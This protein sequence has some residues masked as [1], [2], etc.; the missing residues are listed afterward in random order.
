MNS[1]HHLARALLTFFG[2]AAFLMLALGSNDSR[3]S[4]SPSYYSPP[5]EVV[6]QEI[7]LTWAKVN[8]ADLAKKIH[9]V[10]MR[11]NH[12]QGEVRN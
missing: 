7:A 8:S 4:Y 1:P 12:A 11:R 9:Q 10:E 3:H 6:G 5:P 2:F